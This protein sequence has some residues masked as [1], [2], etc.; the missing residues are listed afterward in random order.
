MIIEAILFSIALSAK[1]NKTKELEIAV[2]KSEILTKE[3]HHRVKNNMQFIISMYRLKLSKLMDKK[4]SSILNEIELTIQA[5]SATHEMLYAKSDLEK[6]DTKEYF[7]SLITRISKS[8]NLKEI[9]IKT[10]IDTKLGIDQSIAL[11][12]IL[13]ELITNSLKYAFADRK[14][15]IDIS[16]KTFDK[17]YELTYKDNGVG[18]DKE[19]TK[20]SFGLRLIN[21]LVRDELKG[22]LEVDG[23][24]GSFFKIVF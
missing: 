11:G 18:F 15:E 22:S 5:M 16:L 4:L 14:G 13:N 12:I 20:K 1:L 7:E 9:K 21:N 3:L 6:I 2:N 10:D 23:S 8:F 17:K 24:K 19:D